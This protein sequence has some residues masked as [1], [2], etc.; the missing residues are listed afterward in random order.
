M[1][2]QNKSRLQCPTTASGFF[3][4]PGEEPVLLVSDDT[5]LVVALPL[6]D[7]RSHALIF[8]PHVV[9]GME[10]PCPANVN[11]IRFRADLIQ[12]FAELT[13][14]L[15]SSVNAN[16]GGI[17]RKRLIQLSLITAT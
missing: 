17:V 6:L 4:F 15:Q 16:L 11:K 13:R 12:V 7:R 8:I 9:R 2:F 14:I 5:S 1:M 3:C 10:T